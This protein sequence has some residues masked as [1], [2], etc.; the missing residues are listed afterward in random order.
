MAGLQVS[1]ALWTFCYLLLTSAEEHAVRAPSF[2]YASLVDMDARTKSKLS[3]ALRE[4]GF[5]SIVDVPGYADAEVAALKLAT[6][7]MDQ[8]ESADKL[9][10]EVYMS[11]MTRRTTIAAAAHDNSSPGALPEWVQSSCPHLPAAV[12][13]LRQSVSSALAAVAAAADKLHGSRP[14]PRLQPLVEGGSHLEH[15]HRYELPQTGRQGQLTSMGEVEA[16]PRSA[17]LEMHTDA[18]LMLAMSPGLWMAEDASTTAVEPVNEPVL[19]VQ[20][21]DGRTMALTS[22]RGSLLILVGQGMMDWLPAHG[23][24]ASP[25]ALR[26]SKASAAARGMGVRAWFG[27]MVFPPSNFVIGKGVSFGAWHTRAR[28]AVSHLAANSTAAEDAP[29][30]DDHHD[31]AGCL[32]S[33]V[34]QR[35]LQ[36][37]SG[38]CGA[39]QIY[40][41]LQCAN[42]EHLPCGEQAQCIDRFSGNPCLTHGQG[43]QPQCPP[44]VETANLLVADAGVSTVNG[45]YATDTTNAAG[46]WDYKQVDGSGMISWSIENAEWVIYDTEHNGG[47]T[48]YWCGLDIDEPWHCSWNPAEG[49]EGP[50]PSVVNT[51][52]TGAIEAGFCN[53]LRTDM[54]MGG[55]LSLSDSVRELNPCLVIFLNEWVLDSYGKYVI[56]MVGAAFA[57]L[58]CEALLRL[59][60]VESARYSKNRPVRT[61]VVR[62]VLYCAHRIAGYLA[63][64]LAMTYSTEI[65]LSVIAGLSLG[66]AVFNLREKVA[67]GET[68]CCNSTLNPSGAAV[69]PEASAQEGAEDKK[70]PLLQMTITGMSCAACSSTVRRQLLELEGVQGVMV[71]HVD[72]KCDVRFLHEAKVEPESAKGAVEQLGYVVR[73]CELSQ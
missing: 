59:R 6:A 19:E 42:V 57:G 43:C 53:G 39:G 4:Q 41:W 31:V 50:A 54:H 20:L 2:Q 29:V 1:A 17:T 9:M 46:R 56:A 52:E 44:N 62:V 28:V 35:R 8:Q 16:E 37:L 7:C 11:D 5:L 71:S 21:Q 60:S 33:K 69:V 48:L 40:C 51:A 49:V 12:D 61:G 72:G 30:L 26:L 66:F 25:H 3:E 67:E 23:F 10:A 45:E 13:E 27:R 58:L 14:G 63:M 38:S 15:F 70:G 18:G 32:S 36:D 65:F 55:F 73:T 22:T 47:S 34:L 24:R 68:A 64:L